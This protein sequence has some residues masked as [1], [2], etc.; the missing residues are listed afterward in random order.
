MSLFTCYLGCGGGSYSNQNS[1]FIYL[2][3]V[4]SDFVQFYLC[5]KV[6]FINLYL[7]MY[8]FMTNVFLDAVIDV[9]CLV[10]P[11]A[12]ILLYVKC[13]IEVHVIFLHIAWC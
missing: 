3:F 6:N 7:I 9:W 2:F 12:L 1:S 10:T 11:I 4:E 13:I 8:P 5:I